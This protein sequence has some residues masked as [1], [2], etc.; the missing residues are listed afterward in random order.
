MIKQKS[1][2]GYIFT[3]RTVCKIGIL[4]LIDKHS[5][6]LSLYQLL[7]IFASAACLQ[8]GTISA[9]SPLLIKYYCRLVDSS[10]SCTFSRTI[11]CVN[12]SP[13]QIGKHFIIMTY[14]IANLCIYISPWSFASLV[15]CSFQA[16]ET[17]SATIKIVSLII[18]G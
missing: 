10:S 9:S 1:A 17:A 8:N 7:F 2:S 13:F 5:F 18:P 12:L 16:V 11:C 3:V 4:Q 6:R 14:L 15:V